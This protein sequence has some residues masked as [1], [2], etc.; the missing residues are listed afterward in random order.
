MNNS[1]IMAENSGFC[2]GVKRAVDKVLSI[3]TK[4]PN[5]NIYTLGPL[6]HNNDVVE[7]LKSKG[8]YS[9]NLDEIQ[10]K[11]LSGDVIIIRS[12]G[13]DLDTINLLK[14][15]NFI[16]EDATCPYVSNIHYKVKEYYERGYSIIIVGDKDHPEVKGINGWCNNTASIYKSGKEIK[17]VPKKVCIVSQTTEKQDS[18][19]SVVSVIIE[20]SKEIVAFN[21]IC[22]ATE[23]RQRAAE[24]LSKKVDSMVVIGGFNS[25]NTTK[26]YEICKKNCKNT[27]HIENAMQLPKKLIYENDNLIIG[28]TAGA[29]TPDWIIK[30]ATVK[31][32]NSDLSM[33]EQLQYMEKYDDVVV[34]KVVNGEIIGVNE[35]ELY[36]NIGYK[37]DAILPREE[38]KLEDDKKM[39]DIFKTGD[40]VKAKILKIK[41]SDGYVVLSQVELQREEAYNQIKKAF[42]D[43]DVI[44]IQIKENVKG[45]L[46]GL[47]NG[48]RIFV[49]AS[50]VELYHVEN[51]HDYINKN[52]E[53]KIIEFNEKGRNSRIVASRREILKGEKD[54]KEE[55]TWNTIK[56]GDVVKGEVKRISKY[57]AF[58]E[59][60][61]VD[62]L[63]HVSELSWGRVEKPE[64]ILKINDVIDVY[65]LSV[66]KENKKLALSIKKLSENPWNDVDK[67]YPVGTITL[68]KV[69]RF[70]SFGAFVEIEPGVDGLVH[71]SQISNKKIEKPDDVLKISQEIKVKILEVDMDKKRIALSIRDIEEV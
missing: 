15:K 56:A 1:I 25:S 71:I 38:I 53:V 7:Y 65:V 8:V 32:E 23:V 50:H 10:E 13:V 62:G 14:E 47:Y 36:V 24:E 60:N 55:I 31:M 35:K 48:I 59:V 6:I 3:K 21:T 28:V 41:N 70:A 52:I 16:V 4:Y 39:I 19:K 20:K 42:E 40:T 11:L 5:R 49:P 17:D 69:V 22:N 51:L 45:G 18:W 63:L 33:N 57:G 64:D 67:K 44:S 46:V 26:L 30:E 66:D 68:G 37:S 27:Y 29:S 34:G 61:G 43:S 12:H 58:V 9:V 2:F 54:K